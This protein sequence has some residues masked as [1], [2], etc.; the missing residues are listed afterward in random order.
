MHL[1]KRQT[2][3]AAALGVAI[4]TAAVPAAHAQW[5]GENGL[6]R[7]SFV[8]GD[9]I[10]SVAQLE[11]ENGV[12]VVDLYAWL[13]DVVPVVR[14]GEAFLAIGGFEFKLVAE[15]A[16]A[17]FLE[18]TVPIKCLDMGQS[19]ESCIVG[20]DP[21]LPIK[22]GRV[23]LVHW[24]VMFQGRPEDVVFR[25][26]TEPVGSCRTLD[27]CVECGPAALY[28][29][30][31]VSNQMSVFFGAGFVPAYLNP[32]GEPDFTPQRGLCSFEDV[33]LFKGR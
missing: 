2:I 9:S 8:P 29:G 13:A 27:G 11:A 26:D 20:L 7:F 30:A 19:S 4:L 15:G 6:I 5:C 3:L 22:N 21:G 33:G 1:L 23:H 32:T 17:F 31:D 12:T 24:K 25:L 10:V 28:I 14:D 16:E 18:K